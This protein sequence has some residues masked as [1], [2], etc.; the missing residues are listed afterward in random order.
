VRLESLDSL[1][2]GSEPLGIGINL[3]DSRTTAIVGGPTVAVWCGAATPVF[4]LVVCRPTCFVGDRA[5]A[6]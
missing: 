1:V 2:R 4:S 5:V 3:V 6:I